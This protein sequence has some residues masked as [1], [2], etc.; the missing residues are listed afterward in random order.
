[1]NF[2]PSATVRLM[3]GV[4][5]I[6][7]SLHVISFGLKPFV[8]EFHSKFGRYFS[9]RIRHPSLYRY[10]N[11]VVSLVRQLNRLQI[12]LVILSLDD[13]ICLLPTFSFPF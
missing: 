7:V 4:R 12:V 10:S 9:T 8:P 11:L 13:I 3:E 2:G 6:Q 1:M 5:L